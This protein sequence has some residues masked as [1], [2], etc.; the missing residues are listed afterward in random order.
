LLSVVKVPVECSSLRGLDLLFD[1]DPDLNGK[2]SLS[3]PANK[4]IPVSSEGIVRHGIVPGNGRNTQEFVFL[5]ALERG[6]RRVKHGR[7]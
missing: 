1:P 4:G 2:V 5:G 3:F 6:R 7:P